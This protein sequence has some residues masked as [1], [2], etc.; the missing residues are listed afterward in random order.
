MSL[1]LRGSNYLYH[2]DKFQSNTKNYLIYKLNLLPIQ[3]LI[4]QHLN[5]LISFCFG[6]SGLYH[7]SIMVSVNR[8]FAS[9]TFAAAD[10]K[11]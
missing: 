5:S 10:T 2:E 9:A 3:I 1:R 7:F 4:A 6:S 8:G 11:K